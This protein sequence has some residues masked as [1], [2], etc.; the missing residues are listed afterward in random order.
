MFHEGGHQAARRHARRLRVQR[1]RVPRA[2]RGHRRSR[3]VGPR[4]ALARRGRATRFVSEERRRRRVL[5]DARTTIRRSCIGPS[6]TTTARSRRARRCAVEV[7][8]RLGLVAR[9]RRR[10]SRSPSATWRSGSARTDARARWARLRLLAALD[11]VPARPGAWWSPTAPAA[12]RCSPRRAASYAPTRCIAGPWASARG[13][14]GQDGKGGTTRAPSSARARCA[15]RRS[16][17]PTAAPRLRALLVA[18]PAQSVAGSTCPRSECRGV[19][20]PSHAVC[21]PA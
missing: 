6:R 18:P 10:R 16:P 2:R 12:T 4:R 1:G 9:R 14:R 8:V 17:S 13:P 5:P 7:L 3:V 20:R 11:L 19:K 15:R 21:S